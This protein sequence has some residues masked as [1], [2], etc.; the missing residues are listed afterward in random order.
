MTDPTDDLFADARSSIELLLP[1]DYAE[2]VHGK[3]Y[4]MGAG[5]GAFA[6]AAYPALLRMSV[7]VAVRIPYLDA[8]RPHALALTLVDADG[9]ELLRLDG[10]IETSRPPD[11]RGDPVLVPLAFNV[12]V[13]LTGPRAL[14][15]N[16]RVDGGPAHRYPIR[17]QPARGQGA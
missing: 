10:T 7:A 11:T 9:A 5:W 13:E 1:A 6:P 4:L 17:A 2:V 15:L 12:Q 14:E 16:A 3:L 8:G